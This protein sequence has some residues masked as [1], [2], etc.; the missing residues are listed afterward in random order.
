M[1]CTIPNEVLGIIARFCQPPDLCALSRTCRLLHS[2][3]VQALYRS[4]ALTKEG[5]AGLSLLDLVSVTDHKYDH[6][7]YELLNLI[8]RIDVTL[9]WIKPYCP[10]TNRVIQTLCHMPNLRHMAIM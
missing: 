5:R 4:I 10:G 2:H 3:A 7:R 6:R 9:L 1:L 8:R